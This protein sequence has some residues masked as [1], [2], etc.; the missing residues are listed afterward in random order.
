MMNI[1]MRPTV[2]GQSRAIE[3]HLFDFD[4]DIYGRHLT[5]WLH[6]YLRTE[7]KFSGLPALQ[8]QLH[9]DKTQSIDLLANFKF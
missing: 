1:G 8:E 5:V 9:K 6:H 4:Q 7:Q 2:N 3:V